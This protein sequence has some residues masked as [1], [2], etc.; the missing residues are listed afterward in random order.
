[1][2]IFEKTKNLIYSLLKKSERYTQTDMI[3][4]AKGGFW[5]TLGQII[6]T[7]ASLLLAIAF[8][9][10]L[11]PTTYGNYKYILSLVGV[12]GIFALTGI[13]TAVTQAVARGLEDSFYTGFKTK[14]K[15]GLLGSLVAIGGAIYYWIRGNYLLPIPLLIS[16]IF[17][18]LML[19]SQIYG[20]FLV[21]RRLFSI[22]VKYSV[23]SRI[24]SAGAIITTL[25]I[26]KN[27][28]WIIAVYFVSNTFLNYSFYLI[29]KRKFQPNKKEDPQTLSYG[30]HLSLM[31]VFNQMAFYLDR[32]LVFHYLG[33]IELAIYQFAIA[34]PEQ[35]KGLL[36]NIRP[37]ALPKF[38]QGKKEEIKKTIFKKMGKLFLFLLPIVAIYIFIA[39]FLYK[40]F[41]P[42]YLKSV[43]YSQLFILSLLCVPFSFLGIIILQSQKAQKQLYQLNIF[44]S[45]TK[46]IILFLFVYFYGLLGVILARIISRFIE[47]GLSLWLVNKV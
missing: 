29:S 3:Y 43:F 16:A 19:A 25:L 6:S 20:S 18:P 27:L 15:W 17:L 23:F 37:L 28:F 32:I 46:I 39:P 31:N 24:V 7:A 36:K 38:S 44:S 35:I 11:D 45:I 12:L 41:F 9:N 26:T 21:G 40:I 42:Q 2:K 34:P 22:Q 14:L 47:A 10:L 8:A 1:M 30:K 5:L 13:G 33:A 4:L